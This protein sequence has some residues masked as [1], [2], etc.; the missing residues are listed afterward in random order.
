M[1]GPVLHLF[2]FGKEWNRETAKAPAQLQ[3]A[4][5]IEMGNSLNQLRALHT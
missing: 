2:F 4:V 3:T 5:L 1:L